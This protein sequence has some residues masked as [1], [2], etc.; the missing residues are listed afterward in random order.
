LLKD[1][2]SIRD[3]EKKDTTTRS[4]WDPS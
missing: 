1:S 2:T 3:R 4:K